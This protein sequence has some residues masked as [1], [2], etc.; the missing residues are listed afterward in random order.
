MADYYSIIAHAVSRLPD[1]TDDARYAIYQRAR[2][3]LR[4]TLGR[5]DPAASA[6]EEVALEAAIMKVEM[7]LLISIMRRFVR[8]DTALSA[9]A[10]R[11]LSKVRA[12]A[13]AVITSVIDRN[14]LTPQPTPDGLRNFL[15]KIQTE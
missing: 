3:A 15:W 5:L 7:D 10:L 4:K 11:F 12:F 6:N 13:P 2:T 8:E 14:R 9:A 1:N